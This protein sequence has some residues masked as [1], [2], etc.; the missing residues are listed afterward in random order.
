MHKRF[1]PYLRNYQDRAVRLTKFALALIF[2]TSQWGLGLTQAAELED[3]LDDVRNESL[4]PAES[5]SGTAAETPGGAASDHS[6]QFPT[7]DVPSQETEVNIGTEIGD[8]EKLT[9]MDEKEALPALQPTRYGVGYEYR[10]NRAQRPERP[11]RPER[12]QRPG[13]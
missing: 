13:R 9:A 10:M 3:L 5:A 7:K 11:Q 6:D 2:C 8:K 1:N 12:A 4:N